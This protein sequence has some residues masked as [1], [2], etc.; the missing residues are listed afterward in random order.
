MGGHTGPMSFPRLAS[1]N[2][3][4]ARTLEHKPLLVSAIDK[5]PARGTVEVGGVVPGR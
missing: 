4:N 2:V 3:G 5:L 1:V